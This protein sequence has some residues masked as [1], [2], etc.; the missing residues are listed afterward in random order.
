[1]KMNKFILVMLLVVTVAWAFGVA[2][3]NKKV[4]VKI[5][6]DHTV[7]DQKEKVGRTTIVAKVEDN[8]GDK[9][10]Y[11]MAR[12]L[13]DYNDNVSIDRDNYKKG[14]VLLVTFNGDVVENVKENDLSVVRDVHFQNI[15]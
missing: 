5:V 14:D 11:V 13:F 6:H 7:L 8:D 10:G 4:G 15:K 1:M 9:D 2:N 12:N 3:M